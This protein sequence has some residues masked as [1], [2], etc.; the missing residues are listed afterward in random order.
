MYARSK[1]N[2]N[3]KTRNATE[4]YEYNLY[5][6]GKVNTTGEHD[7]TADPLF[8]NLSVDGDV[9]DFHLRA[10]SPAIGHGTRKSYM[11]GVDIEGNSRATRVDVGA[12]QRVGE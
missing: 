4:K 2:C 1:G 12:Y 9:A 8:V 6:N 7:K 10:G 5:F 3:M 11:S